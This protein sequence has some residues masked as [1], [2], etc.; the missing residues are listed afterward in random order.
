MDVLPIISEVQQ[1]V[2]YFDIYRI[3]YSHLAHIIFRSDRWQVRGAMIKDE[4]SSF[5][6]NEK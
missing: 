2:H 6:Q 1:K 5:Y 4:L 3:I